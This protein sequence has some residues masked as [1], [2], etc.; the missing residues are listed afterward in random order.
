L[1]IKGVLR[2]Y[3]DIKIPPDGLFDSSNADIE[4]GTLQGRRGLTQLSSQVLGARPMGSL[5]FWDN[6]TAD[7]IFVVTTAKAWV[8]TVSSGVWA[9]LDGGLTGT[10]D[11][12]V[13]VEQFAFGSPLKNRIY[14]VNGVDPLK[15]WK[16]GDA[17]VS[18]VVSG[19]GNQPPIM[20]DLTVIA[21][22][23]VGIVGSHAIQWSEPLDDGTVSGWPSLNQRVFGETAAPLIAIKTMGTVGGVAYKK[24]SIWL[25]EVTGLP[26]GSSFRWSLFDYVEGPAGSNAV[27]NAGGRHYYMTRNGRIGY[28]NGFMHKWVVDG[29]W[30]TVKDEIDLNAPFRVHGI[31]I[32]QLEE[33][34]FYYQRAGQSITDG[35]VILRL[36]N[37]QMGRPYAAFPGRMGK[38]VTAGCEIYDNNFTTSVAFTSDTQKLYTISGLTDDGTAVSGFIQTGMI[39]PNQQ[40]GIDRVLPIEPFLERGGGFGTVTMKAVTSNILDNINGVLSTGASIDLTLTPPKTIVG[41]D[42]RGRFIGMRLEWTSAS[43]IKYRGAVLRAQETES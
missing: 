11:N 5:N 10:A 20:R 18:T 42:A 41:L 40:Q 23:L 13:S 31:W 37:K 17:T 38:S 7:Y 36:E 1:P 35:M 33:V 24:D 4:D 28:F 8:Y 30:K 43:T 3:Q 39:L 29:A 9:D 15:T 21:D 16:V 14:F 27:V 32:P 19:T 6:V 25:G 12:P 34:R 22:R 2:G 26:G